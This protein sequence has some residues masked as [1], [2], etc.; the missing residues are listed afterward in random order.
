MVVGL[1]HITLL[2]H[3]NRSLKGKR[4]VLKG[5]IEK[6]KHRF[7]VSVAEVGSNDLWQRA[8]VGF[9]AVGSDAQFVNS[10]L[11]KVLC[12][13]EDMQTAEVVDSRLEIIHAGH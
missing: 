2:I 1:C 7:N 11:D 13:I 8:E 9:A 4:Q 12:F 5:I 6:V 10:V 3:D